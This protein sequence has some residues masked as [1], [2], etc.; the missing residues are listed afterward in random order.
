MLLLL[1]Y[2][3]FV[4]LF[5]GVGGF[6]GFIPDSIVLIAAACCWLSC[7]CREWLLVSAKKRIG[8]KATLYIYFALILHGM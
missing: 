6:P 8:K 1:K 2:S 4:W 7:F 5:G 3:L